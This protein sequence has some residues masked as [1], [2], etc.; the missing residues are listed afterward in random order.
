MCNRNF[1]VHIVP[2]TSNNTN[3]SAVAV[4]GIVWEPGQILELTRLCSAFCGH[5]FRMN[6]A[7]SEA[8][9]PVVYL[10]FLSTQPLPSPM[11]TP[12]LSLS[13]RSAPTSKDV[14]RSAWPSAVEATQMASAPVPPTRP[15]APTTP[16][17][18]LENDF[19]RSAYSLDS[20]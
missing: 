3:K 15:A 16:R 9:F 18:L 17:T 4:Q 11:L 12:F 7:L 1:K 10:E 20:S 8:Y 5:P 13:A 19:R 2:K 14:P 6:E